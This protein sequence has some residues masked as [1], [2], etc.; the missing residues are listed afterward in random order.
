MVPGR[1]G[2]ASAL[3]YTDWQAIHETTGATAFAAVQL[4]R[5]DSLAGVLLMFDDVKEAA[6]KQASAILHIAQAEAELT[7]LG[8]AFS[9]ALFSDQR[10][11][12]LVDV[13]REALHAAAQPGSTLTSILQDL[14]MHACTLVEQVH[15]VDLAACAAIVP[16]GHMPRRMGELA[17]LLLPQHAPCGP[18]K[19]VAPCAVHMHGPNM[20]PDP[21]RSADHASLVSMSSSRLQ[22]ERPL[23]QSYTGLGQRP[24]GPPAGTGGAGSTAA[25]AQ[26]V[27]LRTQDTL[28]SQISQQA[29]AGLQVRLAGGCAH[30]RE[31]VVQGRVFREEDQ[32]HAHLLCG[33]GIWYS[34]PEG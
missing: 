28:L 26:M 10:H 22:Y 14:S 34:R 5:D 8:A 24:L 21:P 31:A 16:P 2:S 3:P 4:F 32:M 18:H 29:G 19:P 17:L 27:A 1:D 13:A 15:A 33:V 6:S 30:G 25:H 9:R 11:C 23:G 7:D 12:T 20:H